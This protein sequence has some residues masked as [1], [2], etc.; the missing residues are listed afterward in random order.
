[1]NVPYYIKSIYAGTVAFLSSLG[2]VLVGDGGVT[3]AQWVTI[4]LGVVIASGGVYGLQRAPA[5]VATS[6]K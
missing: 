1:M 3:S 4:A 6:V 2:A 5:T